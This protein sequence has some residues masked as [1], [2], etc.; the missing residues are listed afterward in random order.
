MPATASLSLEKLKADY[1]KNNSSFFNVSNALEL[2]EYKRTMVEGEYDDYSDDHK[3][4]SDDTEDTFNDMKY[5][6]NRDYA[7]AK[8][9]YDEAL[10]SVDLSLKSQ[11]SALTTMQESIGNIRKN[12]EN[13]KTTY[14]QNKIKYELGLISK[15]EFEKSED[16]YKDI[17]SQLSTAIINFNAQYLALT[18]YSYTADK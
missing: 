10:K 18:Q 2:Y 5:E 12:L 8:Y 15:N 13:T 4:I 6:A 3:T 11:L 7:D 9:D 17:Q 14:E 16:S 1:V